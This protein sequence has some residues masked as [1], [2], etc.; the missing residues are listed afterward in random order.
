MKKKKKKATRSSEMF[1][2]YHNITR[3]HTPE[4]N[5]NLHRR[6]QLKSRIRSWG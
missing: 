3:R 6:K 1:I 4:D 5:K 2:S